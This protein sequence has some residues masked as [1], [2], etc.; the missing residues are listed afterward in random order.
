MSEFLFEFCLLHWM[1]TNVK[2]LEKPFYF[3]TLELNQPRMPFV[4]AKHYR[5]FNY[6]LMAKTP[7]Y[8]GMQFIKVFFSY[9]FNVSINLLF[10]MASYLT[11]SSADKR[12]NNQLL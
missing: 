7:G 6:I 10:S 4:Q 9:Q 2:T 11:C 8:M 5:Q 3:H 1:K 12:K